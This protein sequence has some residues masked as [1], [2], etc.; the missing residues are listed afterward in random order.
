LFLKK[1]VKPS[2]KIDLKLSSNSNEESMETL[3]KDELRLNFRRLGMEL[4]S[5]GEGFRGK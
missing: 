1:S 5:R 4:R 3:V 2:S